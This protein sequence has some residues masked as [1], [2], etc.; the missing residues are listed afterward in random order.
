M[1]GIADIPIANAG[2][3]LQH[4]LQRNMQPR[5]SLSDVIRACFYSRFLSVVI[6]LRLR[7]SDL[8][9]GGQ[10]SRLERMGL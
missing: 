4:I 2:L 5:N 3:D 7:R 1:R 8:D 10:A 9:C 6:L